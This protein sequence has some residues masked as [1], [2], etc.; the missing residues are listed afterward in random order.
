M[1]RQRADG[2]DP[3]A[4]AA[5]ADT[6]APA[7]DGDGDGRELPPHDPS[8]ASTPPSGHPVWAPPPRGE[9]PSRWV[10]LRDV[11]AFQFKLII[12]G[13]RDVLLSPL[14][15]IVA[16]LGLATGR[17]DWFYRLLV[18]GRRSDRWIDLFRA[19]SRISP[20]PDTHPQSPWHARTAGSPPPH[21]AA[22]RDGHRRQIAGHGSDDAGP[23]Q[24]SPREPATRWYRDPRWRRDDA[25]NDTSI[26]DLIDQIET[27]L[28][29]QYQRGGMTAR[30]KHSID[31]V[32]DSLEKQTRR[33]TAR[34]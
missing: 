24:R 9:P 23:A 22:P 16:L 4:H 5:G 33:A 12:D 1:A 31:R 20:A 7:Q 13:T 28:Q 2:A 25:G 32:L 17:R 10:L 27:R 30:A 29:A 8:H 19:A 18:L 11:A 3:G 15:L 6:P 34:R 14:S 26:D 21:G